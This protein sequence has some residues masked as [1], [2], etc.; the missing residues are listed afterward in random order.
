M[1]R[2]LF[3]S[4]SILGLL[5]L[6]LALIACSAEGPTVQSVSAAP[7]V[8]SGPVNGGCYLDTITTCRIHVDN[9][10]PINV[11]A[12]QKLEAFQLLAVPGGLANGSLLYDF[13]T[14]VAN[15][16]GSYLPS[17]VKGD[18]AA[19]CGLSY[20]LSLH[21]KDTGDLDFEEVGRTNEFQCPVAATVPVPGWRL[22]LP[23][24]L[25]R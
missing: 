25:D 10:Q 5:P 4:L 9:W 7:N 3:L 6:L 22:Y 16:P 24:I 19:H 1:T 2:R 15:P 8:F 20:H 18:F 12:G 23:L 17:L 11:D 14:D 13:R 21:A